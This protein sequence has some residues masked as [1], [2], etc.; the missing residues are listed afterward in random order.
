M[1]RNEAELILKEHGQEHVLRHFDQLSEEA[2]QGLLTQ[3]SEVNWEDLALAG[4]QEGIPVGELTGYLQKV[5]LSGRRSSYLGDIM[6]ILE[7]AQRTV[8]KIPLGGY[9]E[10]EINRAVTKKKVVRVEKKIYPNDP[11]PCG[12]GKKYKNCCGRR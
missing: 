3:I 1:T 5:L 4:V 2:Q 7:R 9:T 10:T 8:R 6:E 12:S 11:C